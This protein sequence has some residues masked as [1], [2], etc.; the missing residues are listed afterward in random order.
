MWDYVV[1]LK[2]YVISLGEKHEVDPLILGS[3]YLVSKLSFFSLLGW[4]I[5]NMRA[6][7]PFM[8]QLLF[9]CISFSMPY[10]YIIIAGRNI[11]VWVYVF[12]ACV[13]TYGGYTIWKKVTEKPVS[14]ES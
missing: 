14:I 8:M 2:E 4:V 1:Q 3:L 7:K 9:A 12:I 5:K 10:L 6:K 13:F 11:S